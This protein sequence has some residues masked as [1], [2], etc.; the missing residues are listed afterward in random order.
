MK[1]NDK[2]IDENIMLGWVWH[3]MAWPGWAVIWKYTQAADPF[4][5]ILISPLYTHLSYHC[6]LFI[7]LFMQ[8]NLLLLFSVG[9]FEFLL[10]ALTKWWFT[11][12]KL[13]MKMT[14]TLYFIFIH[15]NNN[16]LRQFTKSQY[17][18][19]QLNVRLNRG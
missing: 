15:S 16:S 10:F 11:I 2:S 8:I 17:Y 7:C 14:Y 6:N 4:I 12:Y 1:W 18:H 3:G 9:L 19:K 5:L 13:Y